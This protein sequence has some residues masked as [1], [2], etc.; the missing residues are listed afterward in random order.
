MLDLLLTEHFK[1]IGYNYFRWPVVVYCI[2]ISQHIL[3]I[4]NNHPFKW[5]IMVITSTS[6]TYY[7]NS[8]Q[9][10]LK[11]YYIFSR[12]PSKARSGLETRA[13]LYAW[14]RQ[15]QWCVVVGA[16]NVVV[17]ALAQYQ[18]GATQWCACAHAILTAVNDSYINATTCP[19]APQ[20]YWFGLLKSGCV[21]VTWFV[22]VCQLGHLADD[23][24]CSS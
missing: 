23:I 11:Y 16:H 3:T 14:G 22:F 15:R 4:V 24:S 13:L 5:D 12:N 17:S 9:P 7:N 8:C 10:M 21:L 6:T 18:L 20:R 2:L 1:V 19:H